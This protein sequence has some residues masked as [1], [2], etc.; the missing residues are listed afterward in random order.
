MLLILQV[1]NINFYSRFAQSSFHAF[2]A[3]MAVLAIVY[4]KER[5]FVDTTYFAFHLLNDESFRVEH[6]RFIVLLSEILPLI[7]IHLSLSM[8]AVLIVYSVGHVLYFY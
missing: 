4:F 2:F 3:L 7:A 5:L 1:M 8:Q 6:Q